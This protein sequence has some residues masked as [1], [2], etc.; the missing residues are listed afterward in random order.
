[1]AIARVAVITVKILR[2]ALVFADRPADCVVALKCGTRCE[3]FFQIQLHG[4]IFRICKVA[5]EAS[6]AELGLPTIKLSTV[7]LAT[8]AAARIGEIRGRIEVIRKTAG[9]VVGKTSR[10]VEEV[11]NRCRSRDRRAVDAAEFQVETSEDA[12]EQR[13]IAA[14]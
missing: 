11:T 12:V 14:D 3:S 9:V 5:D 8:E 4:V 1:M 2:V 7:Q 10:V 6:S 13:W